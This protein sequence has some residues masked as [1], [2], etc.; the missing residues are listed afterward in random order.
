V[1]EGGN[2]SLS[3]ESQLYS[4]SSRDSAVSTKL[5]PTSVPAG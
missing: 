2:G 4:I 5:L 3:V 1:E